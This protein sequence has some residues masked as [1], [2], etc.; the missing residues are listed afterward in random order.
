MKSILEE[1]YYGNIRFGDRCYPQTPEYLEAAKLRQKSEDKLLDMLNEE[2][3]EAFDK[4]CDAQGDIEGI[5]SFDM[6]TYTLRFGIL[7]MIEL[8]MGSAEVV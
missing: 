4:Y 5:G 8:F 6:F 1:L 2:G 3:K 7:L